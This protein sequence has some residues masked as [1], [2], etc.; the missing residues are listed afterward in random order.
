MT[1]YYYTAAA[2]VAAYVVLK[3]LLAKPKVGERPLPKPYAVFDDE[4][5]LWNRDAVGEC[6]GKM[7]GCGTVYD[8]MQAAIK[9]HPTR[10][11]AGKSAR[12]GADILRD[13]SLL[14]EAK[15]PRS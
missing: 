10:F 11:T 1:M 15:S 6:Q 2:V 9:D 12:V 3:K 14:A 4:G 8:V 5:I 7:A 13:S